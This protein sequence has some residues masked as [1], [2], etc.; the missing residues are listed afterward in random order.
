MAKIKLSAAQKTQIIAKRLAQDPLAS[1]QPTVTQARC[2]ACPALYRLIE[3][4]NQSGKTNHAIVETAEY[5][6]G[7]HPTRPWHGPVK[8][9]VV[10]PSR[11]QLANIWAKR[12]FHAS[13]M[14]GPN[15]VHPM[16]PKHMVAKLH[17]TPFNG[18]EC[19]G[20]ADLRNGSEIHFMIS[21][22]VNS[23]ERIQGQQFDAIVRDEAVGNNNLGNELLPRLL[24]AQEAA[25]RGERIGAGWI[26]W[27]ATPTLVN[28]EYFAFRDRCRAGADGHAAFLIDPSENPAVS[29]ETRH[30]MAAAMSDDAAAI[31]MYGTGSAEDVL[32]IYGKQ[33]RPK[34]HVLPV[35]Y[36]PEPKDNLWLALDPGGAGS[37]SHPT[38]MLIMA[39]KPDA[40]TWGEM[41]QSLAVDYIETDRLTPDGNAKL[42]ADYLKGRLL[43]GII[44]DPMVARSDPYGR[45]LDDI[46]Q[47]AFQN[48]G[49]RMHQGW[50]H[51]LNRHD[52]GIAL[53]QS[54]MDPVPDHDDHPPMLLINPRCKRLI[55]S[56][57]AYRGRPGSNY[58]G[59]GGVV[60]RF[61]EGVDCIRYFCSKQ[62]GYVQRSAQYAD[63]R[64]EKPTVALPTDPWELAQLEAAKRSEAM[65]HK[66]F[67]QT[68]GFIG[69]GTLSIVG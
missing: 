44:V 29:M 34:R 7:T 41:T 58:T 14:A 19:V 10:A 5:A 12:L 22:D 49:V 2:Q 51:G 50:Y 25:R 27:A 24:V 26:L 65:Y 16:I 18:G 32:L 15:R 11:N 61:D 23:W 59:Q 13:E 54:Y 21:G 1:Y 63:R 60:K 56:I 53:V 67:P 8:I 36:E 66:L 4:P 55:S 69:S 30:S 37:A 43:E 6:R 40:P 38:G 64:Q 31:R 47:T 33:F 20:R 42:I 46:W 52:K 68:N 62:R 45:T 3:G 17:K 57:T 48:A 28:D 39:I 9:L 35:D